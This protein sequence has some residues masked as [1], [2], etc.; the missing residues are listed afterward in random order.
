LQAALAATHE[1]FNQV[2]GFFMWTLLEISRFTHVK[3]ARRISGNAG[4]AFQQKL[5]RR[6]ELKKNPVPTQ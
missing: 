1:Q 5:F 4:I 3:P 2:E 6:V